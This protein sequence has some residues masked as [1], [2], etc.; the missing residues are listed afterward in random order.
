MTQ[1]T[2]LNAAMLAEAASN[3]SSG[4]VVE[5]QTGSVLAVRIGTEGRDEAVRLFTASQA[6]HHVFGHGSFDLLDLVT[7]SGRLYLRRHHPARFPVALR[8]ML[9]WF[10]GK[11]RK[12]GQV[13]TAIRVEF[14]QVTRG[15]S[16]RLGIERADQ[17]HTVGDGEVQIS[18]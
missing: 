8:L 3:A 15:S 16:A 1:L 11:G 6:L 5:V 4:V 7:T 14:Q 17:A 13:V 18:R 12:L 2:K 9:E 10:L